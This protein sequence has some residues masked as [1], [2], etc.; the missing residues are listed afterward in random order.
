MEQK[1]IELY[2]LKKS[3]TSVSGLG[4]RV[5]IGTQ[6]ARQGSLKKPF[7]EFPCGSGG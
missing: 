5:G 4:K 7:V 6:K 3:G 1:E 2:L